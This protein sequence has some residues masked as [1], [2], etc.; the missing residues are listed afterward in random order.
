MRD[1]TIALA[2]D[3]AMHSVKSKKTK[4]VTK[5]T[6]ND[7]H[8]RLCDALVSAIRA[9]IGATDG[10]DVPIHLGL[11]ERRVYVALEGRC[12]FG[13]SRENGGD[14]TPCLFARGMNDRIA[15][16]CPRNFVSRVA[17]AS[18]MSSVVLRRH[19]QHVLWRCYNRAETI[20]CTAHQSQIIF[21]ART[22]LNLN[23]SLR[24][25]SSTKIKS[26][27]LAKTSRHIFI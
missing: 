13:I 15:V 3:A 10:S 19:K 20:C 1:R 18:Q 7:D 22:K 11:F 21:V 6:E 9:A 23:V 27:E 25:K 12:G 16:V 17:F 8:S 5:L 14:I 26:E 2:M 4:T 24:Q